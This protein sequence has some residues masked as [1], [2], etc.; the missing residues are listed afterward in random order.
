MAT[1][2]VST[3]GEHDGRECHTVETVDHGVRFYGTSLGA[4]KREKREQVKLVLDDRDA[5]GIASDLLYQL[6]D[7]GFIAGW[8]V[9]LPEREDA[10]A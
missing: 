8:N 7:S 1:L 2:T 10:V 9:Q 3:S 4:G 5:F 6:V